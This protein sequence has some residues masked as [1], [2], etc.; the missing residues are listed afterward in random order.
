M[1]KLPFQQMDFLPGT[2]VAGSRT[3]SLTPPP[4][5]QGVIDSGRQFYGAQ[6]DVAESMMDLG[7]TIAKAV[8]I[9]RNEEKRKEKIDQNNSKNELANELGEASFNIFKRSRIDP[10]QNYEQ[11]LLDLVQV[12]SGTDRP[13]T[14]GRSI[15]ERYQD[16]AR[17]RGWDEEFVKTYGPFADSVVRQARKGI[18]VDINSF[19]TKALS[20]RRELAFNTKLIEF[21]KKI[22]N[23]DLD[24]LDKPELAETKI[25]AIRDNFAA[26]A[27]DIV[28]Q[29]NGFSGPGFQTDDELKDAKQEII[30]KL[31]NHFLED[32][33]RWKLKNLQASEDEKTQQSIRIFRE[34]ENKML[35]RIADEKIIENIQENKDFSKDRSDLLNVALN[36]INENAKKLYPDDKEKQSKYIGDSTIEFQTKYIT[37]NNQLNLKAVERVLRHKA[38]EDR[39][40]ELQKQETDQT[41]LVTAQTGLEDELLDIEARYE[42]EQITEAEALNE[43][44]ASINKYVAEYDKPEEG[45]KKQKNINFNKQLK[46]LLRRTSLDEKRFVLLKEARKAVA[47]KK[48]D[49]IAAEE[50]RQAHLLEQEDNAADIF[51]KRA[52]SIFEQQRKDRLDVRTF[53]NALEDLREQVVFEVVGDRVDD[54]NF[55]AELATKITE[56]LDDIIVSNEEVIALRQQDE[57]IDLEVLS[58][59]RAFINGRDADPSTGQ[60]GARGLKR[61]IEDIEGKGLNVSRTMIEVYKEINILEKQIG[62]GLTSNAAKHRFNISHGYN[63]SK[64]AL[65]SAMRGR[66]QDRETKKL[67]QSI[68]SQVQD[69]AVGINRGDFQF[70]PRS[71]KD[72]LNLLT[73]YQ[74][75]DPRMAAIASIIERYTGDDGLWT[76]PESQ[77]KIKMLAKQIDYADAELLVET[78]PAAAKEALK[79]AGVPKEDIIFPGLENT[80]RSRLTLRAEENLKKLTESKRARLSLQLENYLQWVRTGDKR[81]AKEFGIEAFEENPVGKDRTF[82]NVF[83]KEH[84]GPGKEFSDTEGAIFEGQLRY[85]Q[86]FGDARNGG[87]KKYGPGTS[88]EEKSLVQLNQILFDFNPLEFLEDSAY[89][90]MPDAQFLE[91]SYRSMQ[92]EIMGILGKRK[93]DSPFFPLGQYR[94]LYPDDKN[95]FSENRMDFLIKKQL[96]FGGDVRLFTNDEVD[97]YNESWTDFNGLERAGFLKT[98]KDQSKR[99]ELFGQ[100]FEELAQGT[101]IKHSDQVYL[102]NQDRSEI[103]KRIHRT[104]DYDEATINKAMGDVGMDASDLNAALEEDPDLENFM[105]AFIYHED[106]GMAMY[107]MF[108]K[109]VVG[110]LTTKDVDAGD[111]KLIVKSAVKDL[112]SRKNHVVSASP[113]EEEIDGM[114]ILLPKDKIPDYSAQLPGLYQGSPATSISILGSP[115]ITYGDHPQSMDLFTSKD[116]QLGLKL[117]IDEEL[118]PILTS[119]QFAVLM[120]DENLFFQNSEDGEGLTLYHFASEDGQNPE[121]VA[122]VDGTGKAREIKLS[123]DK[124]FKNILDVRKGFQVELKPFEALKAIPPSPVE[125]VWPGTRVN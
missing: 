124:L 50:L 70:A 63:E 61:I 80:D 65:V 113:F 71:F 14:E 5:L 20:D 26:F 34:A 55:D 42:S 4:S 2:E 27:E 54:P 76:V 19:E 51:K 84:I 38:E 9:D 28:K 18:F 107:H 114:S 81:A 1:A 41:N 43:V 118:P 12:R 36:H 94:E 32:G 115:E 75:A 111:L 123:F 25:K 85:A 122:G 93:A 49:E 40:K 82:F 30:N 31:E 62:T 104:R 60:K 125:N 78:N 96:E 16:M 7:Q 59:E 45:D 92:K 48:Q 112:I 100:M 103:V 98:M 73:S 117:F 109:Y 3:S 110:G 10:S 88:L 68:D 35:Q 46:N 79:I 15:L 77:N 106:R 89:K 105:G 119:Y 102:E 86:A 21:K 8:M 39:K 37:E 74:E 44:K 69:I 56:T 58:A 90:D 120:N 66:V 47:Q 53:V 72:D 13:M 121:K 11:Q 101:S 87:D 29:T 33:R 17:E 95:P 97:S 24:L 22:I 99:P 6:M 52:I 64:E 23:T 91:S 83:L 116:I 57:E 67:V 108:R